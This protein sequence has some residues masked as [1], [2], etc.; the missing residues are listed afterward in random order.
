[1]CCLLLGHGGVSVLHIPQWLVSAQDTVPYKGATWGSR[2]CGSDIKI[3]TQA[4]EEC[5]RTEGYLPCPGY[6]IPGGITKFTSGEAQCA[7][8]CLATKGCEVYGYG[9]GVYR[10]C[11]LKTSATCT[12]KAPKGTSWGTRCANP[13]NA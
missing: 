5:S 13:T 3:L 9:G 1:M 12:F 8:Y 11:Q 2:N 7:P 6:Y 4:P 10:V